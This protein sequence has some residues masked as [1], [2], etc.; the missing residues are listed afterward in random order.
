VKSATG[1]KENLILGNITLSPRK[2]WWM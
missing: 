1:A 2:K